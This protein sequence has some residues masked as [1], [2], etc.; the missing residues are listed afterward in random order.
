MLPYD[1]R[2]GAQALHLIL[3]AAVD[4]TSEDEES[5]ELSWPSESARHMNDDG[6]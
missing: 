1:E 5:E 6:Q 2:P 4:W 3:T